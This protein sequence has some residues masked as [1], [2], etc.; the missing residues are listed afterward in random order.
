MAPVSIEQVMYSN[1]IK[2]DSLLR[3][4]SEAFA[5]SNAD[6][7]NIYIDMHSLLQCIYAQDVMIENYTSITSSFIN[8]CAHLRHY[9]RTRHRVES[10]IYLVHSSNNSNNQRQFLYG[11]NNKWI[12][13]Y[14]SNKKITELIVANNNLLELLCPY[15]ND[16]FFIDSTNEPNVVIFDRICKDELIYPEYPNIII[17]KDV[18]MY[19]IPAIKDN[20]VIY[21]PYRKDGVDMSFYINKA[22]CLNNYVETTRSLNASNPQLTACLDTLSPELLSLLIAMTNMPSR[23]IKSVYNIRTA[24]AKIVDLLINSRIPNGYNTYLVIQTILD[25]IQPRSEKFQS[26]EM[27][28]LN[29]FKAI[30]MVFQHSLYMY[31][32]ESADEHYLIRKIDNNAVREISEKYFAANPLDLNRL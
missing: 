20:T 26:I 2:Y 3:M 18:M 9:F 5:G 19:Q 4:T 10:R 6:V 31:T 21:R 27:N 12:K 13:T 11:Y 32:V 28:I 29:R 17:S 1:Y 15:L 7:V 30:D 22:N 16:I 23:G 24:T 25:Y 8:L 14:T